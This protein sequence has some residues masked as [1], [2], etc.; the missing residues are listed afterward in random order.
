MYLK[1][2]FAANSKK[3]Y[4]FGNCFC[5]QLIPLYVCVGIGC[6]GAVGYTARLAL[7]NPDVSWNRK[8]GEIS[9]EEYRDKQYK[10][11]IYLQNV[12]V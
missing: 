9:N 7:R 8:P 5:L 10:V 6:I 1:D 11:Y 12:N 4:F 3:Y 2:I